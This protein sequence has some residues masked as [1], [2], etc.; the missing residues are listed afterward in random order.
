MK[1]TR[2]QLPFFADRWGSAAINV[3]AGYVLL[4][5]LKSQ[6]AIPIAWILITVGIVFRLISKYRRKRIERAKSCGTISN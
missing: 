5:S 2:E 6:T 1:I 3:G 4:S